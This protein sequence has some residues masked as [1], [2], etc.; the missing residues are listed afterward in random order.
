MKRSLV[1]FVMM[2]LMLSACGNESFSLPN[3]NGSYAFI[4]HLKE[5]SLTILD[6]TNDQIEKVEPL[7]SAW[8][9]QVAYG[10]G[11][12]AALSDDGKEIVKLDLM[13]GE[14]NTVTRLEESATA[15]VHVSDQQAFAVTLKEKN[16]V[17]LI[18]EQ[19]GQTMVSIPLSGQLSEMVV[20]DE[21]RLFV[22]STEEE[23]VS[24][25]Y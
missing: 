12:V 14:I 6:L 25:K 4:S 19:S 21:G 11:Q 1:G 7:E 22:L 3:E 8:S 10:D 23:C 24:S 13:N 20:T 17:Q 9:A 16:E 5:P 18:D 15:I 2:A